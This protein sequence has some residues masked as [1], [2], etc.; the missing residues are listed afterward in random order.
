M[1]KTIIRALGYL[2]SI[3]NT[4]LGLLLICTVYFPKYIKWQHGALDVIP[5]I[6]TLIPRWAGAQAQGCIVIYRDHERL[7][8][9]RLRRHERVHV[10]QAFVWGP[11]FFIAYPAASVWAWMQGKDIY[12]DNYFEI[13]ARAGEKYEQ[14]GA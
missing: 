10:K 2:W 4:C 5:L 3:P 13:Q 1:Q 12:R 8:R 14:L 9:Q 6:G 7:T 11:L